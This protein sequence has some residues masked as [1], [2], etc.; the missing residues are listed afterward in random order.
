MNSQRG[1]HALPIV[2]VIIVL[3]V[4][5]L[6]GWRVLGSNGQ[7]ETGESDI[8]SQDELDSLPDISYFE[9][10]KSDRFL[11][12]YEV[13]KQGHPFLGKN[14][15]MPHSGGHVHFQDTYKTWPQGGTAPENY[16]PIYAVADGVVNRIDKNHPVAD[17]ERYGIS[18]AIAKDGRD[19]WNFDYSIEPFVKEPSPGF[20]E[21]FMLVAVGDYV[22]K[23]Q[24]I[25]YMYL[26]DFATGSHIHFHLRKNS[27]F[28][29]PAIFTDEVVES[30]RATWGEFG[31]QQGTEI[32]VCMGWKLAAEENP[33]TSEAV[34][35]L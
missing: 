16:P 29:A 24:I 5:G 21:D 27:N 31:I 26:P 25:G 12:D 7:K 13:A 10:N 4:I 33:F 35:C 15:P 19:S 23:G 17:H 3:G 22:K 8:L 20:Y 30:A 2:I 34:E 32:P 28:Y 6:A 14:S 18:I 11:V 1:F 9:T